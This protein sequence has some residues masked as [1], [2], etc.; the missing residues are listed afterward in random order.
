MSRAE[1]T[2]SS[3]EQEFERLGEDLALQSGR[4]VAFKTRMRRRC[5]GI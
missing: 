2:S 3:F 1:S 5:P 4:I